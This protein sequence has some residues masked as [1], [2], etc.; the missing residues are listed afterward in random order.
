MQSKST[1]IFEELTFGE[2]DNHRHL[3]GRIREMK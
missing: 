2:K 3:Y 1:S